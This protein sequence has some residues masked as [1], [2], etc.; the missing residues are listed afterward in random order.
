MQSKSN[1]IVFACEGSSLL[2][3]WNVILLPSADFIT[4]MKWKL[5]LLSSTQF[6]D[7]VHFI[8]FNWKHL[9]YFTKCRRMLKNVMTN[10]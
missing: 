7:R 2:K 9:F 5:E 1:D 6:T 10:L 3:L 4:K 8:T